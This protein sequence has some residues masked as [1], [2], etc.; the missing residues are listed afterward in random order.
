MKSFDSDVKSA[1]C[2]GCTNFGLLQSLKK[3]VAA[4]NL[5][6]RNICFVSGIGQAAKLPHYIKGNVFNGLHGRALPAATGIK[7]VRPELNVI[8]TTG[9]GDCY[10]E[11]GNHFI[12]TI[13]RNPDITLFVHNNE[14]YALTKGQASPTTP[15][16]TKTRLQ[17][18]GVKNI[19]FNPVAVAVLMGCSFVARGYTGD[20]EHL[21]EIMAEAVKH[22]GFSFVDIIQPCITFGAHLAP[23]FAERVYRIDAS[24]DV[25][26][27][28]AALKLALEEEKIPSGVIYKNNK[29]VISVW[30]E[31]SAGDLNLLPNLLEEFK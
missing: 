29:A 31:K 9:D 25:F 18:D 26:N 8:V 28:D 11:G 22:K 10:G 2:P 19:T 16:G 21:F 23:Y 17:F 1:W 15:S 5:E 13:R 24:H 6:P 27:R 12:H 20:L 3:A 30:N 7:A 4:L 14:I